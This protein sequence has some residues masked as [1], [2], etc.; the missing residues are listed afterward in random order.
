RFAVVEDQEQVDKLL[1]IKARCPT[2]EQIIYDDPRGL[3]NY[4]QPFLHDY[5]A[6]QE[7]G[8]HHE[9]AHPGFYPRQVEKGRDEDISIILY[10][11]GTTGRSKGAILAAGPSIRAI[12]D[13]V[14]F[15]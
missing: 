7:K 8:R 14:E 2:L 11:S 9:K 6:V 10:T 12:R 13:T 1:E 3:R 5:E 4:R 15:D